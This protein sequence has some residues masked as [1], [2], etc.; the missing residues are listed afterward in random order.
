MCVERLVCKE[1]LSCHGSSAVFTTI[2][3]IEPEIRIV[4]VLLK[5]EGE[6]TI[7]L[8]DGD[9]IL[10]SV[11]KIGTGMHEHVIFSE[12][13]LPIPHVFR[14]DISNGEL[15]ELNLATLC[16]CDLNLC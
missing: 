5:S 16:L 14:I 2:G 12:L 9:T 10:A 11:T 8:K 7:T 4:A 1:K 3:Y 15:F 6:Y 13:H